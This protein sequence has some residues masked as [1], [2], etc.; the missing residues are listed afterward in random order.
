MALLLLL[1]AA[2]VIILIIA[3]PALLLIGPAIGLIAFLVV[4]FEARSETKNH[5]RR[6]DSDYGARRDTNPGGAA[7]IRRESSR[8]ER[9]PWTKA[10]S[11]CDWYAVLEVNPD[12]SPEVIK[13]AYKVLAMLHHPD[14]PTDDVDPTARMQLINQAYEVLRDARTRAEYD[15]ERS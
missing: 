9:E 11:H 2:G 5:K 8:R 4:F 7:E 13:A 1:V 12:A 10:K 6:D 14:R 3:F 15:A